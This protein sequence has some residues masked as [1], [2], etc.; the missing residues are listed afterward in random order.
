MNSGKTGVDR[1]EIVSGVTPDALA[2]VRDIF[3][4]YAALPHNV[5]R[6]TGTEEELARLPAPYEPPAGDILTAWLDSRVVGCVVLARLEVDACEMK[7][8][9][10]RDEARGLG[11][12][13]RLV[14]AVITR[15]RELGYARMLLDT[16]PELAAARGL[17]AAL[18]FRRIEPYHARY[19]DPICFSYDLG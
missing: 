4:E 11:L 5:G 8:L 6:Q 14:E 16:A 3:A 15:G 2:A 17:Y 19:A 10:V 12:G 9:Y 13:R 18:G 1:F 7:R